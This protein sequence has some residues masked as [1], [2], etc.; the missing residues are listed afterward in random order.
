ME[1]PW[2]MKSFIDTF[3]YSHF[4]QLLGKTEKSSLS[5]LELDA[6]HLVIYIR[7]KKPEV[8]AIM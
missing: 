7:G 6:M 3:L 8:K 1:N 4:L 2:D 5:K